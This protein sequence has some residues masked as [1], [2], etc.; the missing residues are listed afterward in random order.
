MS[1]LERVVFIQKNGQKTNAIF[2]VSKKFRLSRK[3]KLTFYN[4][5][6]ELISKSQTEVITTRYFIEYKTS[7]L[8]EK[9][10]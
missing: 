2:L 10:S 5:F 6:F 3:S 7:D 8:K 9:F 4:S 1:Y